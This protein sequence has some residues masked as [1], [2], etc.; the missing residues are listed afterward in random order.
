M[1]MLKESQFTQFD[2]HLDEWFLN[3]S[4]IKYEVGSWAALHHIDRRCPM[5]RQW[6]SLHIRIHIFEGKG[7]GF[8]QFLDFIFK[9]PTLFNV[10]AGCPLMKSTEMV[11]SM[12]PW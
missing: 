12:P 9:C 7:V 3:V 10:M 5:I 6:V 8:N 2:V 11:S 1:V 4:N